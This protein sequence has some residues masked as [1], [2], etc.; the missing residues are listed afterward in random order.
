VAGGHFG[1]VLWGV[2][3]VAFDEGVVGVVCYGAGDGGFAAAGGT[4]DDEEGDVV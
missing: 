1:D 3:V 4:A 2:E